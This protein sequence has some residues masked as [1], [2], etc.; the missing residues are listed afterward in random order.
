MKAVQD[1]KPSTVG[2]S[3]TNQFKTMKSMG[4]IAKIQRV[5]L[6]QDV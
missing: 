6:W 4:Q 2:S 5:K 3:I 1:Y